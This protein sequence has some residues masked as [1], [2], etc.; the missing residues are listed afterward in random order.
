[1]IGTNWYELMNLDALKSAIQ[2]PHPLPLHAKL[3]EALLRQIEDGQL[4]AGAL[5]PSER[6]LREALNV[7]RSTVRQAIHALVQAG[8]LQSVPGKGTFVLA[9]TS[10]SGLGQIALIVSRPNFHF[11]YPQLAAAFET[12]VRQAGYGLVMSLHNDRVE[13]LLER[14]DELV[15]AQSLAGIAL[16]PPRFGDL[17]AVVAKVK[18]IGVPLVFIGRTANTQSA[19]SVAVDNVQIGL[20]ATQHL[21]ELGH[22]HILYIGFTDY[23]TGIERAEGYRQ[24]MTAAGLAELIDIRPIPESHSDDANIRIAEPARQLAAEIL[25]AKNRSTAIFCFNDATAMGVYKAA[26]DLAIAMPLQLSLVSVD[27]LPTILHFEV[28]LTTFALPSTELGERSA[29]LLLAQLR[30]D[31]SSKP[32]QLLLPAQFMPRQSSGAVHN[33]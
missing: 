4:P 1:M 28:P 27:N 14:L 33:L 21:I 25:T 2:S 23:S 13:T 20:R 16:V 22:R 5:L 11:F 12:A 3:R 17:A 32:Q 6:I 9:E 30:G 8:R 7:S 15:Q 31:A 24:A 26:R 19:P 18:R 29:D 10:T